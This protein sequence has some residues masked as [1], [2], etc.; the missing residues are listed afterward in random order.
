MAS[1]TDCIVEGLKYPF[2]DVKKLLAFGVLFAI[3]NILGIIRGVKSIDVF[4]AFSK[5]PGDTLMFKFSQIPPTDV[6]IIIA[7]AIIS[8][9]IMLFIMGYQYDVVKFSIDKKEDLPGFND[10]TGMLIKGIKYFLVVLAYNILP[11]ILL[12]AGVLGINESYGLILIFI[13]TILFIIAYFLLIMSLNNMIANDKF[14][15]AF[16]FSEITGKI[17]NLGWGKYIGTI[18]FTIII[19]MIIMVAVGF[20]LGLLTA[21]LAIAVNH[22]LIVSVILGIIEGLIVNSYAGVFYNRVLGS[23][24]SESIK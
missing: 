19:L 6:G 13:S 4:R 16:D 5:A 22:V 1:I 9:I 3:L 24:Y 14:S 18:L 11:A 10:I 23:I 2:N 17:S 7:I 21:V 15:K 20:I 12:I 8:F